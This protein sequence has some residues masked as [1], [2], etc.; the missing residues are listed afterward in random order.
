MPRR[1][2]RSRRWGISK[3]ALVLDKRALQRQAQDHARALAG[4]TLHQDVATVLAQDF[5]TDGQ[6][7]AGALGALGANE[8]FEDL[9]DLVGRY[10]DTVVQHVDAHPASLRLRRR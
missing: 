4:L 7:Q 9:S 8:G 6:A 1:S 3:V 10:S 5:A 2:W